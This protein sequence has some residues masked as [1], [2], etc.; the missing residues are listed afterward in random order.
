MSVYRITAVNAAGGLDVLPDL[1]ATEQEAWDQVND[2]P[3][4]GGRHPSSGEL[5][6]QSGPQRVEGMA[7]AVTWQAYNAAGGFGDFWVEAV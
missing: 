7:T 6:H 3:G 5:P 2:S 1:Y 4:V